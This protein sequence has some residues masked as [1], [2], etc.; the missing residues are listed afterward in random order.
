MQLKKINKLCINVLITAMFHYLN[1][2]KSSNLYIYI[3]YMLE[4]VHLLDA[5]SKL[6]YLPL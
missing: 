6:I 2:H 3:C 4:A 1:M 5:F